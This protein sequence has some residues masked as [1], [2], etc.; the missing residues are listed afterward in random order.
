[1]VAVE[2]VIKVLIKIILTYLVMMV[3]MMMVVLMMVL[4]MLMIIDNDDIFNFTFNFI[5]GFTLNIDNHND[6]NDR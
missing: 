4:V 6:S 1:M 5:S 2:R 3:L